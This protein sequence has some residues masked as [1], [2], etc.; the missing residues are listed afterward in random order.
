MGELFK[1]QGLL[2]ITMETGYDSLDNADVTRILYE[3]PQSKTKGY[4][5]AQVSGTTLIYNLQNGDIDEVGNWEFQA[6]IEIA[7]AYTFGGIVKHH[8]RKPLL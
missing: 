2:R 1:S 8:F 6:Y 3:K 7:G 5:E 4:F